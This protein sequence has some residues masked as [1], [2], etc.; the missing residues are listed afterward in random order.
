MESLLGK[1]VNNVYG[2]GSLG[3]GKEGTGECV[4]CVAGEDWRDRVV[5]GR[6]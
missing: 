5:G 2:T 4:R 6:M 1:W 3:D